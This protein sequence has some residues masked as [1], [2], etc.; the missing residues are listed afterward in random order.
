[1]I[2]INLLAVR[3]LEADSA[4]RSQVMTGGV[5][6]GVAAL[7]IGAAYYMQTA[8]LSTLEQELGT[9][10]GEIQ[11]LNVKV[12]E[13]GDLQN[14]I[15]EFKGKNKILEDLNQKKSGP[16]HVLESLAVSTPA[17]L[18]LTEL[19]E[20]GGNVTITGVAMDNQTI[21][22]FLNALDRSKYFSN[23]DLVEVVQ[24]TKGPATG[25]RRF[26]IRSAVSYQ[27]PAPPP[28]KAAKES[29]DANKQEKK[30]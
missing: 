16:V 2:R 6:L 1:M 12:K 10:R 25:S 3:E 17:N 24:D 30:G 27:P 29:K 11:A 15:K 18:W 22:D 26:S 5:I 8:K 9:L 23:V 28:A 7:A 14:A 19:R 21:A 20:S 13:V 4:R